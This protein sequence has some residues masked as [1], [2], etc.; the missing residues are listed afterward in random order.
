MLKTAI[1][2]ATRVKTLTSTVVNSNYWRCTVHYTT[3]SLS[4]LTYSHRTNP[5]S[6]SFSELIRLLTRLLPVP[7]RT[8]PQAIY[9]TLRPSELM[10]IIPYFVVIISLRETLVINLFE[11]GFIPWLKTSGVLTLPLCFDRQ[12]EGALKRLRKC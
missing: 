12:L 9:S 10:A 7:V 11:S 2:Q 3:P 5:C 1:L 4:L 6:P 8:S